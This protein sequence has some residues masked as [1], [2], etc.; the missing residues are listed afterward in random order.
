MIRKMKLPAGWYPRGVAEIDEYLTDFL[1]AGE[2]GDA[3]AVAA[4]HAGWFFSGKIA[5]RALAG[6][7]RDADVVVVA[8]GH[9]SADAPVLFA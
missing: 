6:L 2:R 5:A 4:P 3:A 1:P 7:S 8:G 9:L